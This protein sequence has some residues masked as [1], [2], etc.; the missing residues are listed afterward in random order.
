[1]KTSTLERREERRLVACLFIDVVGSTEL[2][3]RL[4][5]ERLKSALASAFAAL[6]G[7]IE[8]EGGTV[9]KYVGDAIYALFGAP[10]AHDDDPLRA[11]RAAD[12]ARAWAGTLEKAD[13][14]FSVRIGLETGEAVVDL[15]AT[16]GS[17]QQMSVGPVV[18]VAARLC[19]QAEPGQVLVG[20]IAHAA[21]EDVATFR[22]LGTLDLKGLG[23]VASWSLDDLHGRATRQRVPFVGRASELELL[24]FAQRRAATRSV[25]ALVSGPPGQGK[26]RLVDEFLA[27][28]TTTRVLAARCR[29]GGEIGSLTPLRELLLGDRDE[30]QLDVLVGDAN[31]DEAESSRV[32]DALAHSAGILASRALS[33]IGKG[34]RDDEIQNA[35]RR[36]ARGLA[37]RRPLVMRVEDVHWA[38]PEVVQLLDRLSLSGDPLLV[39]VTARPEFADAAGLRPTGDRFFIEL[40]G[41]ADS[42]AR[43][44]AASAGALEEGP[45]ARAEGNPL[46]IVELARAR[47]T[48]TL[49]LTLQGA[50]GSRLDE[51]DADDR[52]LLAHGAIVGE[53]FSPTDAA[54]LVTRPV[55]TVAAALGRLADR[56]YLDHVDGRFRFHH[57]LLRDVA[58]G[59]LLIADRMRLHARY[60]RERAS[61]EDVEVLAHHWWSALEGPD[62]VWVW[63]SD[64]D[65]ELMR[66][67][68]FAAHLTAG[69]RATDLFAIERAAT[70][71]GRAFDLAA[72]DVQR[73]EA[74]RA[75]ADAYANDLRGDEAWRAY[76][77]ARD[78][79]VT[80]GRVPPEL[81]I[82]ALKIR[83]RVGAFT[84]FPTSA[85]IEA[86]SREAES[87]ARESGDRAQLARTLVYSAF[88]D[89]NPATAS[90]DR[91]KILEAM[92]LSEESDPATRREILGWYAHYLLRNFELERALE[93][94]DRIDMLHFES[95]ELDRMEHFRARALIA[96]R[97][98]DLPALE[99]MAAQLVAIS[100]RMGPHLRTHADVYAAEAAVARGNWELVARLADED[101]RLI[102]SSPATPFCSAAATVLAFGAV[103]H[104]RAGHSDEA[105]ALAQEIGATTS[106]FQGVR[107]LTAFA[108]VFTGA[109]VDLEV[110]S[111]ATGAVTAVA[112]RAHDRALSMANE[113]EAQSHGGARFHAAL[114]E[115]LREE[116]A[117]DRGGPPPRH[118]VLRAIGYVGWSEMLAARASIPPA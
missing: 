15:A 116:V 101:G 66:R 60:A 56:H 69:R 89:R 68:G 73:G 33:S 58:Y 98:G 118:A 41:L 13:V 22:S 112:V 25:L 32:R 37:A 50:L 72:D 79:F 16:E 84:S 100:R 71:L 35:W 11:L 85:E 78:H 90:G 20:P 63:G 111:G 6:S 51:L 86:L 57:S 47:E 81:Y 39:I 2:T 94:L 117:R 74:K 83:M 34:E 97:R 9:E 26:T 10:V 8:R 76:R 31:F 114:A 19:Q 64:P 46:F 107:D 110:L 65:L 115:A 28:S 92:Q 54:A 23:R 93:V 30:S 52:A 14:P 105:R 99:A 88:K 27:T 7:F 87:A 18:N 1:M 4:G 5:P 103:V 70:L 45:L 29:P 67:E 62:A 44:L 96:L 43:A 3:V 61:T 109:T 106:T 53:T 48:G 21:T 77:E 40:D 38:A 55:A 36:L 24:R 91:G 95:N 104:A 80:A 82:G 108:L 102:R 17:R 49:P 12:A 59:R 113:L 75:L 42:E